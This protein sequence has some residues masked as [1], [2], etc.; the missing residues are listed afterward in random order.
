MPPRAPRANCY[1]ERFIRSVPNGF[2]DRLLMYNERHSRAVLDG[3]AA[4]LSGHRPHQS[5]AQHSP[6]PRPGRR[7]SDQRADTTPPGLQRRHQRRVRGR[8]RSVTRAVVPMR[9]QWFRRV[10]PR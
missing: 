4:R 6:N 10:A 3:Y 8:H 5:L 9:R 7:P 1:A 2:T